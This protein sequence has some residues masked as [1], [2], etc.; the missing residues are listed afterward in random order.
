MSYYRNFRRLF[1]I[2]TVLFVL[3]SCLKVWG[4][5]SSLG[6][7]LPERAP[8]VLYEVLGSR[9]KNDHELAVYT[10]LQGQ[11]ARQGGREQIYVNYPNTGYDR[12]LEHLEKTR[13]VRVVRG[14]SPEAILRKL[15]KQAEG[16]VLY[17][18]AY[19][20]SIQVATMVAH[21]KNAV[22][23]EKGLEA[24][25]VALTGWKSL[26]DVSQIPLDAFLEKRIKGLNVRL[27]AEHRPEAA[28][29]LRDYLVMTGSVVSYDRGTLIKTGRTEN[30][31]LGFPR[32]LA[33]ENPVTERPVLGW[34]NTSV[35]GGEKMPIRAFSSAAL[36][37][38]PTSSS[39]NLSVLSAFA[40]EGEIRQRNAAPVAEEG[41]VHLVAFVLTDGDNLNWN[42]KS[43]PTSPKWFGSPLRGSF[44]MN[45]GIAP[46]LYEF[47]PAAM[48]WL[49]AQS[50]TE[51]PNSDYFVVGPSGL[52]YLYPS[53]Y[54]REL[55]PLQTER[56]AKI[57]G[58]TGLKYVQVLDF[59]AFDREDLWMEYLKH[60]EIEG[61]IQIDYA[62]YHGY[63]GRLS[64]VNGKPVTSL[65]FLMWEGQKGCSNKEV[66]EAIN[67]QSR[68]LSRAEGYSIV[69]VHCWTKGLNDVKEVIDQLDSDIRVVTVDV[70]MET[71]KARVKRK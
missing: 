32:W 14:E 55:L 30:Y 43:F 66:A 40:A 20:D 19:P 52:G 1:Q 35:S 65:R 63:K 37:N 15:G 23:M 13:G 24:K 56:L 6:I 10:T 45:Y 62:P 8:E 64:W 53:Y 59:K 38:I 61:L 71:I 21:L 44:A 69:G 28:S 26:M 29:A 18:K 9:M 58:K 17:D 7:V 67:R 22:I 49:Y 2:G 12:F 33:P 31:T 57:M 50:K 3:F 27:P 41:K 54:P 16:Y 25:M 11:I 70:L 36:F 60:E 51:G 39:Y 34:G 68:D 46:A 47:A 4:R 42:L 5:E 48:E